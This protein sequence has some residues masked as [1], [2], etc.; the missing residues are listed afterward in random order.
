MTKGPDIVDVLQGLLNELRYVHTTH[1]IRDSE[2]NSR[3]LRDNAAKL[4]GYA[5][6]SDF[7]AAVDEPPRA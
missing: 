4:L 3:E 2:S 6:F 7:C 5:D 1:N